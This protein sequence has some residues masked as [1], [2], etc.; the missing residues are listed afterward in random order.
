MPTPVDRYAVLGHPVAH[1]QSPFIHAEFARQTGQPIAYGRI[2]CPPGEFEAT[3]RAF[4]ASADPAA[5]V[6][7]ARG[8]NITVPFKFEAPALA[9]HLSARAALAQAAN[10]LRFDADGWFADNSDGIGLVRDIE[11]GAGIA[12][13]GQRVL[14]VGAG[15]AAA[16]VLGPLIEAGPALVVVANRTAE[17]AVVLVER[18]RALAEQRGVGLEARGLADCG[19]HYGVLLNSSAS[20]LAGAAVPV[21]AQTL[22]PGALA[23]DMMYGPAAA[24]FLAWATAHDARGRDGLGMLVE[25]AAEAFWLWRGVRPQTAPVLAALAARLAATCS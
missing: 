18:H 4:I 19:E 5:G 10:V 8:C 6:G 9:R 17:R 16:G 1:S 12:L 15:G 13:A 22:A 14:L 21:T 24:P 2:E 11:H 20:S 23:L 25:Q 7:P 3:V